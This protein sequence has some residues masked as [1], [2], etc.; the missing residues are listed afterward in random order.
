MEYNSKDNQTYN[1]LDTKRTSF[2]KTSP[3]KLSKVLRVVAYLDKKR[4]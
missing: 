3:Q 4:L 1:P 2:S